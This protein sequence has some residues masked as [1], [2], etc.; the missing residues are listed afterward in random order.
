MATGLFVGVGYGALAEGVSRS[1]QILYQLISV[2]ASW[3]W[4]FVA[5]GVILVAIN[6]TMGLRLRDS[7]EEAG[8]DVSQ[9]DEDCLRFRR[10]L[11]S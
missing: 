2:G 3:G 6:A 10:L 1:E 4:S 8:L 9:H 7:D 11:V 5:T